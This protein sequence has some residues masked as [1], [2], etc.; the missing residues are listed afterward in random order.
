MSAIPMPDY[1]DW[2]AALEAS[3]INEY[4]EAN[5]V[6]ETA[7]GCWWGEKHHCTFCGLNGTLMEFR[8]KSADAVLAELTTLVSRHK[9]LD[10]IVVDNIIDNG[11]FSTVL[12]RIAEL[13]WDLRVHYEVKANLKPTEIAAF[14]DAGVAHVQPGIESLVSPVLKLMD[15]GV[16]GVRN[17]RTIRDGESAGLTVSWNWLYGFPGE[18]FADYRPVTD[19]L[20]RLVHLQ[21][22]DGFS[23]I[24]L[25]R[26]SPYFR[27]PE[28]GFAERTTG[29]PYRHVYRIDEADLH[30][31]VYMFDTPNQ[32]LTDGEAREL[33]AMVD[34][35][36]DGYP[37]SSL[38]WRDDG[39]S[40]VIEDRRIGWPAAEHRIDSAELCA[41]Y[42]CLEEGRSVQGLRRRLET[43]GYAVAVDKLD[44]W[45]AE[46]AANGLVFEENGQ[47]ISLATTAVPIKVV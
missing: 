15:K 21:P 27:N 34:R 40:I 31:M 16:S 23:R 44:A 9:T 14:R 37:D 1:D 36:R 22:P 11:Y 7:R 28:L 42:R 38:T 13:G 2:F 12:P 4:I 10:V 47:W 24:L 5:L 33:R 29:R 25:E 35:W 45:L 41:A 30:D 6:M 18:R 26:F 43:L 8:S 19:Q 20:A 32:G 3:P 17:V 39:S 46:L